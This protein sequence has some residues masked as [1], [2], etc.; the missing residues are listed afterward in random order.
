M[1]HKL[2]G[3][4][5]PDRVRQCKDACAA[6]R[7]AGH[8]GVRFLRDATLEQLGSLSPSQL[9]DVSRKRARHGTA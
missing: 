4:E 7:A 9:D 5:Y 1:K 2:S 6:M 8:A 3:S